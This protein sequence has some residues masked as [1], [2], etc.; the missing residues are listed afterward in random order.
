MPVKKILVLQFL[1]FLLIIPQGMWAAEPKSDIKG[2]WAEKTI[3]SWKASGYIDG[4]GDGVFKPDGSISRAEWVKLINISLGYSVSG[5]SPFKDVHTEDWFFRDI[6]IANAAGYIS[7]YSDGTFRPAQYVT[8]EE[9]AVMLQRILW[10]PSEA[11]EVSF[12]DSQDL[13]LWS[14]GAV[15]ALVKQSLVSGVGGKYKPKSQLTRA[16]AIALLDKVMKK[17]SITLDQ[18]G[19]YGPKEGKAFYPKSLVLNAPGISV[20][21]MHINGDLTIGSAVGDG[22]IYLD[23]VNVAGTTYV[24]GGGQNSVH[25]KNT[26][27]V[28]VVVDK[29]TGAVRIAVEGLSQIGTITLQTGA[30]IEAE[31]TT[32]VNTVSLSENLPNDTYVRLSGSFETVDV[33]AQSIVIEIPDGSINSLNVAEGASSSTIKME[34]EATVLNMIMNAAVQILGQGLVKNAVVNAAGIQ[35]DKAPD[36]VKV[37]EDVKGDVQVTIGGQ[38]QAAIQP[39]PPTPTQEIVVE[40][41][42]TPSDT[43]PPSLTVNVTSVTGGQDVQATSNESGTIYLVPSSITRTVIFMNLA[44]QAGLGIKQTNTASIS[45]TFSTTGLAPG[46]WSVVAADATGNVSTHRAVTIFDPNGLLYDHLGVDYNQGIF[47][48]FNKSI[49]NNLANEAAFKEALSFSSDNGATFNPLGADDQ[50]HIYSDSFSVYLNSEYSGTGNILKLAAGSLKDENGNVLNVE[51]STSAFAGGTNL[52]IISPTTAFPIP[53]AMNGTIQFSVD[54]VG[55]V[56]FVPET[57][58]GNQTEFDNVVIAGFGKAIAITESD[59]NQPQTL[60]TMNLVP[61][62]Y[63]LYAWGGEDVYV[64]LAVTPQL[65]SNSISYDNRKTGNDFITV[66]GLNE[67]DIVKVYSDYNEPFISSTTVAA[68]QTS[69]TITDVLLNEGSGMFFFTRTQPGKGES[70]PI[71]VGHWEAND[72]PVAL[73]GGSL[74]LNST[75]TSKTYNYPYSELV[76]DGDLNDLLTY[77]G[78]TSTNTDVATVLGNPDTTTPVTITRGSTMDSCVITIQFKDIKNHI[79]SVAVTVTNE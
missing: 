44:I 63:R 40:P 47:M 64:E 29:Q 66:T 61:G 8:R 22:D 50:V 51:V 39:P 7:G 52:T 69:V 48:V 5:T 46:N 42:S 62:F 2:H 73:T 13:S 53:L 1:C 37:G 74:T 38:T 75:T 65:P 43:T 30:N 17:P 36:N 70:H 68:S 15:G 32:S 78:F 12:S 60:D 27:M 67:G 33:M 79:T 11:D 25:F 20:N 72:P 26:V 76:T 6:G 54:R 9:A 23:Q 41:P 59:V 45:I 35:M 58:S 16:E 4:Y 31:A 21:N 14:R 55:M 57:T 10:L 19:T 34:K 18:A 49:V 24:N 56:Y 77:V 28:T 3:E 71:G